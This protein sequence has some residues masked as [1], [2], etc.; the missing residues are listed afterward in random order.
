MPEIPFTPAQIALERSGLEFLQNGKF[1]KARDAFKSLH[2]S[3]PSRALPLLIEANLGLANEMIS[4][5][6][7]SEANQVLAYLKTIAPAT[8]N[9]TLTP[10]TREVSRDAWSAMV[11]LAAERLTS[12]TQPDEL[13]RAADEMILG[14]S[15]P[16]HPGHPDAKAILT[17]LELGYGS[18][19]TA[20]TTILL[21]TVPR[22]SPFSH[23]VLFFKG[24]TALESGD[25]PR[26]ADYFRR[27]PRTSLLHSS[28]P[29][30]LT[31]CGAPPTP[32]PSS[33]TVYALCSWAGLPTLA[34]PLLQV[35]PLWRKKQHAKA[36][37]LLTKKVPGLFCWGARNFKADLTR[38]L[39]T[40][41]IND[42]KEYSDYEDA[43]LKYILVSSRTVARATVDQA[44]FSITFDDFGS[45]AHSHFTTALKN[46]EKVCRVASLSPAMLSRIFMNLAEGYLTA[47]KKD[48]E[49]RCSPPNARK[50]LEHAVKHDPDNLRAWLMQCDL[51]SMGKDTSAYHRF[52]DELTKR[53][54]TQ[55]E[56]LIR[57]GDCCNARKTYTKALRNFES[58]AKIDSV[59]PRISRGLLRA[60][61]GIAEEAYKKGTPAKVKWEMIDSLASANPFRSDDSLWRLRVHRIVLDARHGMAEEHLV[62]L[63]SATLLISPSAFLLEIACRFKIEKFNL[64]FKEETL[65]K[66]FPGR[67]APE[68]LA[69]FLAVIDEVAA[70]EGSARHPFARDVARELFADH[71]AL[72]IRFVA[73]RRDLTTLLI[74]ILSSSDPDLALGCPVIQDWFSHRPIDP[75]VHFFCSIYSFPWLA[76]PV[77]K[78][79]MELALQ[80][81]DSSDP[82][83]RRLLQLCQKN[84]RRSNA[85]RYGDDIRE[86][87]PKLDL[88]YD[89]HG[90]NGE[91]DDYDDDCMDDDLFGL[92]EAV[93]NLSTSDLMKAL[94]GALGSA[95]LPGIGNLNDPLP[96]FRPP[97]KPFRP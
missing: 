88:D 16:D 1:R 52:L 10:V 49:D 36:F 23:W 57:N 5:G 19:A 70:F 25:H 26:A 81:C 14:A 85:A 73:E 37:N 11:P 90:E 48:Q 38:F 91:Y 41:F 96:N 15:S 43:V 3:Q 62:A 55:K 75:L 80:L 4:K 29:A 17:A 59:D 50:A 61:L 34:E 31:L 71:K 7:V 8:S 46:L 89:P 27:V 72:L 93:G 42:H 65:E 40:E 83:D 6:L 97:S 92:D 94:N 21:R 51:L 77:E 69:D 22:S 66:I 47:I 63:T 20:E 68:S 12:A 95:G 53:F 86:R 78:S 30:L 84:A 82:D 28:M 60:R 45:C 44:F 18:A 74:K 56:V 87:T 79:S 9:L 39:T 54:P 76:V 13:I 64:R 32:Q 24:M 35:E 67:P 2:K 58:A 33:K